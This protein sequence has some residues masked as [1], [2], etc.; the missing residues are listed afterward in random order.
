MIEMRHLALLGLLALALAG[1][2]G[3]QL[4]FPGSPGQ[5]GASPGIEPRAPGAANAPAPAPEPRTTGPRRAPLLIDRIV[6]IV[7]K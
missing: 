1:T 6:A 7:N 4:R 2:A 5:P 3:A